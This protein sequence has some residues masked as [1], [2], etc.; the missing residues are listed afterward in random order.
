MAFA[1]SVIAA[2][3]FAQQVHA[4]VSIEESSVNRASYS[5]S[6]HPSNA[7]LVAPERV[8]A[9]ITEYRQVHEYQIVQELIDLLSIPNTAND[10]INIQHNATKLV[11]MLE[12]RGFHTQLFPIAGRGPIVFGELNA[13]GA[14]RTVIFYCHYDGQPVE[15]T[16]WTDSKPF[17]PVLRT[18]A[19]KDGGKVIAFPAAN[20]RYQ[21]DWRIYARSAADDKSPI[22]AILAA[23]D[24]LGAKNIP[25]GVNVKVVLDGEEEAGSPH[26]EEALLQHR[27]LLTG[28][29]LICAD[30]PVHQ[31]GR[32]QINFGNRGVI[33]VKIT[34]YGP[35]QPLHSGHYGNW[36]P[37]PA[38][39]LAQLLASMKDSNGKVLIHGFYDDD[40]PLGEAERKAFRDAPAYDQELLRQFDLA[41]PDGDGESLLQLVAEPSLNIDG[42]QSGWVGDQAKT[43][44]PDRAIAS[45]DMRLVKNIQPDKQVQRLIAHMQKQGYTVFDREPTAQERQEFPLIARVDHDRGYPAAGTRMDLPVS[46][47]LI[48]VVNGAAG[49]PAV[50][51]PTLGGSVPMY[52]FENLGV[53]GHHCAHGQL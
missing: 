52:I 4:S 33:S 24:A 43:I 28:D 53:A 12:R 1:F 51:L 44:I 14:T 17:E 10:A 16:G 8:A 27:D 47:A 7:E 46:R 31:S 19:I 25:V 9:Q 11:G 40:V 3:L 5:G 20:T 39:R 23:L 29:L 35:L 32:P 42:L 48:Q 22:E 21:D 38:M 15:A 26:L 18:A 41:K 34:V 2:P 45:L 6:F 37:N 30:G 49:Q 50:V 13:P 36:A